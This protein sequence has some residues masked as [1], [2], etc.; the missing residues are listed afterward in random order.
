MAGGTAPL[1][2]FKQ[3]TNKLKVAALVGWGYS[4]IDVL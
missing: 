2:Y 1:T 4:T 3:A